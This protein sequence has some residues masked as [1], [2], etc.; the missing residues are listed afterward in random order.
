MGLN[1]RSYGRSNIQGSWQ[2]QRGSCL[3]YFLRVVMRPSQVPAHY[4]HR[5]G[6]VES[7]HFLKQDGDSVSSTINRTILVRE[8]LALLAELSWNQSRARKC[9]WLWRHT[10][11]FETYISNW[12][13]SS[14]AG[15]MWGPLGNTVVHNNEKSL[16][17]VFRL[18]T[19]SLLDGVKGIG[20][21][22]N[23]IDY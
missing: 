7:V 13:V 8:D 6:T 14:V 21:I 20:L 11:I 22:N 3:F 12:N 4:C 19:L 2:L 15:S 9:A 1:T 17:L 5:V 16:S 23:W 18:A 10:V